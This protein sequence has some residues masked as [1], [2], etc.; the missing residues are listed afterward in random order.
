MGWTALAPM[1]RGVVAS[2]AIGWGLALAPDAATAGMVVCHGDCAGDGA[3]S[4]ADLV[5]GVAI[6]LGSQPIDRWLA[7]VVGA[8]FEG[9]DPATE[10]PRVQHYAEDYVACMTQSS[11]RDEEQVNACAKS[12]DPGYKTFQELVAEP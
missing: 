11:T 5:A 6:A 9:A 10:L 8:V 12:A 1:A 3:V 4:I 7:D 2:L